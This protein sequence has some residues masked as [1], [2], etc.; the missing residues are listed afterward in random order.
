MAGC[1]QALRFWRRKGKTNNA[2]AISEKHTSPS[3]ISGIT[4]YEFE[5]AP[6]NLAHVAPASPRAPHPTYSAYSAPTD[7][8]WTSKA[9]STKAPKSFGD[10]ATLKEEDDAG[11]AARRRKAEQ[12]EQ[13]RL[14]F[15]QMM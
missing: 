13:E 8:M 5:K 10:E 15:F 7:P 9:M 4:V 2:A 12:E 11:E 14:D 6:L 3:R 1:L